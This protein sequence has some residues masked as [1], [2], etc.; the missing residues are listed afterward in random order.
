MSMGM[1]MDSGMIRLLVAELLEC[2]VH[3]P[4]LAPITRWI[5]Q[6]DSVELED[7]RDRALA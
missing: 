7:E 5:K 6:A 1:G 2:V 3:V 4:A